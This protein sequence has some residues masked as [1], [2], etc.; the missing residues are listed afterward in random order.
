MEV[1]NLP[2]KDRD[3]IL[4]TFMNN[5][6]SKWKCKCG[7]NHIDL[8]GYGGGAFKVQCSKCGLTSD[9]FYDLDYARI[10]WDKVN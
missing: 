10:E 3:M 6:V 5:E 1:H 7:C 4:Q 9:V 8:C 2:I